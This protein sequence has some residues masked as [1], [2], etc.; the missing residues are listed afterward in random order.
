LRLWKERLLSALGPNIR[1]IID[2]IPDMELVTG[3]QL[4]L[5]ELGADEA[6]NRFNRVFLEF[7]RVF[8][9][10]EHPLVI[11]LDDCNG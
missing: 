9:Q 1:A 10:R 2:V 8:C 6:Q 3:P 4:P 11:F 7:M 5:I